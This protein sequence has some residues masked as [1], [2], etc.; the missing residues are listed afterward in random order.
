MNLLLLNPMYP[1][2]NQSQN[3][4]MNSQLP[5]CALSQT[6]ILQDICLAPVDTNERP[7]FTSMPTFM[8]IGM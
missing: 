2:I 1:L 4:E 7:L 5:K 6:W 8:G 3:Q